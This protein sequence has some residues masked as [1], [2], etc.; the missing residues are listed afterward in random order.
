M[1][2]PARVAVDDDVAHLPSA[3][4]R[5]RLTAPGRAEQSLGGDEARTVPRRVR[6][7]VVLDE[8]PPD[9]ADGEQREQ[10]Q[11]QRDRELHGGHAFFAGWQSDVLMRSDLGIIAQEV[12]VQLD[13]VRTRGIVRYRARRPAGLATGD[14]LAEDIGVVAGARGFLQQEE[15]AD[16]ENRYV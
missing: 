15:A 6:Q 7:P 8:G 14:E 11:R 1:P 3:A 13:D 5:R 12:A 9:L 10:Q 16:A 4:V 2:V